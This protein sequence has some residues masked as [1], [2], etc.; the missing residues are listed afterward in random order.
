MRTGAPKQD[1]TLRA[2]AEVP[3][4]PVFPALVKRW[5]GRLLLVLAFIEIYLGIQQYDTTYYAL[6]WGFSGWLG[7]LLLV[8]MIA[9]LWRYRD[10][11]RTAMASEQSMEE[12]FA[13]SGV[14]M[15]KM[16]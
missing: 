16:H 12:R 1:A 6:Y 5:V 14:E 7:F 4:A 13:S 8:F 11:R 3:E 2:S 9:G 10:Q 15:N